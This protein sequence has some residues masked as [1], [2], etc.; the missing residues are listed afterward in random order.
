MTCCPK[1]KYNTINLDP[2]LIIS[3][4]IDNSTNNIYDCLNNYTNNFE[5][6]DENKWKCDNCNESV[7]FE[8]KNKF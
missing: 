1:C 7:N 4:D 3:L 5:V 6:D 8:K 2:L